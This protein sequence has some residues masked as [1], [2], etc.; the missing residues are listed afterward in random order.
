VAGDRHA[1]GQDHFV[2]DDAVVR[3]VDVRH[4]ETL[5]ADHGFPVLGGAAVQ[6]GAFP[7]NG[8]VPITILV[9]SPRYFKSW[10]VVPM[11]AWE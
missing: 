6:G 9:F 8:A 3:D 5:L 7:N 11:K 1:V 10:G 4:Q 2:F